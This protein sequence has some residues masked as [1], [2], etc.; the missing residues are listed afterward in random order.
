MLPFPTLGPYQAG[1]P[2]ILTG[3]DL[4]LSRTIWAHQFGETGLVFALKL[5]DFVPH[6]QHVNLSVV[7]EADESPTNPSGALW[8]QTPRLFLHCTRAS[9]ILIYDP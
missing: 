9:A 7:S 5:T 1:A 4:A 6:T 2:E 8:L 3:V